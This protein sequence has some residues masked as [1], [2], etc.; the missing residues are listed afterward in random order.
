MKLGI[1]DIGS[2]SIRLVIMDVNGHFYRI[3][4][5]IKHSARLGQDMTPD[6][7]M[8]ENRIDYG[9]L[10]LTHFSN[11]MKT[12]GVNEIICVAT[13]AVRRAKNQNKFLTRA[14]KVLGTEI[15]ILSGLE[16]AYY[17]YIGCINTLDIKNALA[18]DI[19]GSSTELMLIRNRRLVESVSLRLG[20]IPLMEKFD[21]SMDANGEK[22]N[23]LRLYIDEQFSKLPWLKSAKG[24]PLIGIGGSVRTTGKIDRLRKNQSQFI[25]HNYSMDKNDLAQ[26]VD[27]VLDWKNGSGPRPRGLPWDR[28]D[29][30]TGS[31]VLIQ[32]MS[33]YLGSEKVFVSGAGVRDGLLFEYLFGAKKLVPNVLE[34]SL[35]NIIANHMSDDYEGEALWE[36]TEP[37]FDVLSK[38]QSDLKYMKKVM[39]TATYLNDIGKSINFF[40][41]DRNTFY[42]ILNAPIHGISQKQILLA[43]SSAT[44]RSSDDIL[45]DHLGK[46]MLSQRDIRV[47]RKV[48]LILKLAKAI[49]YGT[50]SKFDAKGISLTNSKLII[51]LENEMMIHFTKE[52]FAYFHQDFK[53]TFGITPEFVI[54]SQQSRNQT[55]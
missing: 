18:F 51:P 17:N 3:T 16:E 43:A 48:G 45:K 31:L 40:Q 25:A 41:R 2:N 11:V 12:K 38:K 10:V 1:I 29:I 47:I 7:S 4:D 44:V 14:R 28:D 46:R 15:R 42:S 49:A 24:L 34:F 13:E 37:I 27:I 55:P 5:Q 35:R 39:K 22:I 23:Q 53:R 9:I 21:L 36:I 33:D 20:S 30:F 8:N 6:G 19:G 54:G 50:I 32:S 52:Q 26:I